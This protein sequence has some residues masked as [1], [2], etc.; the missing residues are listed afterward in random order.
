M[1]TSTTKMTPPVWFWIIAIAALLWNLVGVLAF[2]SEIYLM[3][4]PA[5]LAQLSNAE[6]ALYENL[7]AWATVAYAVAVF[8]G[9]L[10][11]LMLVLKKQ[12][13][14]PLLVLSLVGVFVEMTYIFFFSD[15]LRV[16]GNQVIFTQSVV[17]VIAVLLVW[18][19]RLSAARGWIC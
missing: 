10:G 12:L 15:S 1:Q 17:I 7:P 13:A 16:M 19:A 14:L 9:V 3:S 6:R 4:E 11:S 2:A 8:A 5:W 18:F